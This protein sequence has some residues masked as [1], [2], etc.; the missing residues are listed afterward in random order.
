MRTSAWTNDINDPSQITSYFA[1][2]EVVES[3]HTG[4]QDAEWSI[5][6]SRARRSWTAKRAEQYQRIQEIYADAAPIVFLYETPY[7]VALRN[8]VKGFYQIP[9]GQNLFTKGYRRNSMQQ[10][11]ITSAVAGTSV[12]Q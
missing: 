5:S 2:F 10:S 12:F 11:G 6:S 3:L 8:N 7:P 9:L 1:I 4:F